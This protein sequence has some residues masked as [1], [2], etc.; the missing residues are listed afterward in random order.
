MFRSALAFA[1][2]ALTASPAFA[3][4]DVSVPEPAT[5]ALTGLGVV[6]AMLTMKR[7]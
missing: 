3:I 7:R 1:M 4:V 5:L 6:A 2:L